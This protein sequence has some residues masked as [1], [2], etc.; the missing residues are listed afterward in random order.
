MEL[1]AAVVRL[2]VQRSRLKPGP[3][4]T[5]VYDPAP[6]LEVDALE[7]GPAGVVG[8]V[9]DERVLDV[10]HADHP[11]TRNRGSNGLSLLPR[12]HYDRLR[13][14]FGDHL[15]DGVAGESLLLDTEGPWASLDG[16]LVLETADGGR[17]TLTDPVVAAP[18]VE[19]TRFCL[20]REPGRVDDELTA[21]LEELDGG[22][23]GFYVTVSGTGRVERGARLLR[24]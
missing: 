14:R 13:A 6:L 18:C 24:P 20:G 12:A 1:I 22:A 5:R 11:D 9:G 16:P 2:Q 10:H 8:L 17:L 15:V 3:K 7:I 19:F 4:A 21:A 23:R